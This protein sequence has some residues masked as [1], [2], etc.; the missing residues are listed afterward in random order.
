MNEKT[1]DGRVGTKREGGRGRNRSNNNKKNIKGYC[2]QQQQKT[3]DAVDAAD[4]ADAGC[5]ETP[6]AI[7]SWKARGLFRLTLTSAVDE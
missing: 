3:R 5:P 6:A 4:N 7:E 2:Q 1:E